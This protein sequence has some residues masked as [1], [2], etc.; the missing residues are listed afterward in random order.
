MKKII[1]TNPDIN[2]I[3]GEYKRLLGYPHNFELKERSRELADWAREWY[4]RNGNP[5][6]YAPR[7]LIQKP[8]ISTEFV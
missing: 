6:I 4:G 1:N 3:E 8:R 2:V 7:A 5:W